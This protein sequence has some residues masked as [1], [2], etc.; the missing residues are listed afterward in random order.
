MNDLRYAFR[1]LLK[2][3]AFTLVALATLALGIGANSAIFSVIETVLLRSLPFPQA[4]RLT[5]VWETAPQHPGEERQVHSYPDYLDL[6]AQNHTFAGI[7]AYSDASVIWGT[8]DESEDVPGLAVT[9]DIFSVLGTP[10]FFGR[11]FSRADEKP[12]AE[13]V[14][15]LSY[16]FWQRR[17]AADPHV[18]GKRV[19]VSG[20]PATITGVMPRG[21]KFPVQAEKVDYLAP[22]PQ[23][24][25]EPILRRG[26]HFLSI[27][28]CLKP[29]VNLRTARADLGTIAAQ[30][31]RQ[32]PDTNSGRTE[33]VVDLQADVVGDVRPA[34]LVL[35][36][37]VAL[38]LLI[39][40][41]NVA[42]LFLARGAIREREIAIRAALGASRFQIVRQLLL[43]TLLLALLG[44][45]AG[46][47]LASWCT[48][49]LV[50]LG[51]SD[52]PRLKEIGVN[53]VVVAFTFG[54]ALLTSL[55]F[56][57][58][59]AMQVSRPQVEQSLKEAARGSTTGKRSHR[60]RAAFVV[61]QF[62]LSLVLLVG[63]GLLMRS[64]AELRGVQPGF[65]PR[66]VL[67]FWQSLPKARYGEPT[68]QIQ[69][70]DKLLSRLASLPGV[71]DVGM[72][73]PVP[74]S[75]NSQSTSFAIIGQPAA[76][77]GMEPS[78]SHLTIDGNY[79]RTMRIPLLR[80]RTFNERDQAD[81]P[82]VIMVNE[83]FAKGYLGKGNPLGQRVRIGSGKTIREIVGVVGSSK[84][85][86][87]AEPPRAE[88]YIPFAQ[89]PDRYMDIVVR[90]REPAPNEIENAI[91]RVVRAVDAQQFVP[92]ITPLPQLLGR[93]LAQARFNTL[94]LGAFATVA[95]LLAAIGIYG[96]IAYNVTQRTKEIGIRM[97]L[98]AQQRQ[99]LTMILRQSLAMAT[100]GI[101]IGVF[102]A[103]G[104]TRLLSAL[105]FGVG[106]SDLITYA[107]VILL[108]AGAALLAAFV[109]ARRAMKIN[110]VIALHYE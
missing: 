9:S 12:E 26:S 103:F 95:I 5:M 94:L 52:L 11:G 89:D 51:P 56:G 25:P 48:E 40:C 31:A 110:P 44:G 16:S 61:S 78:A 85:D 38:V 93:T 70:F 63:A 19:T 99:M 100:I 81:S 80:G 28:G 27:V 33:R 65:E 54:I 41:A 18:L 10:P 84:H 32:Y 96:V 3:P 46:L 104:A 55:V 50:A 66:G 42:N 76:A 75:E 14:V 39:A 101:G 91:R 24:Y 109:P 73:S 47:V 2:S 86:S 82:P 30:L 98:G 72:V 13:R 6:R 34:L 8:G 22:L 35:S 67:T 62:A 4:D 60:L 37:A 59:P 1:Q 23:L 71:Q 68:Q 36:A 90:T 107:A 69:F 53:G 17:F 64:F 88:F 15:V 106:T 77:P 83:A 105:L 97:A 29:G 102:C 87:L 21:W 74:F 57:L 45:G 79:F 108:L 49:A 7:A 58:V 92:I 20:H 43:E